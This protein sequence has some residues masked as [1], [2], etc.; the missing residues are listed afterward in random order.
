MTEIVKHPTTTEGRVLI[1]V[2]GALALVL[3][4]LASASLWVA[5]ASN[6]GIEPLGQPLTITACT[7][8]TYTTPADGEQG[9]PQSECARWFTAR[10]DMWSTDDPIPVVGQVCH[11][12]DTPVSY[13]VQV[14][15][16][17]VTGERILAIDV[18]IEYEPGCQDPYAIEWVA[19]PQLTAGAETGDS[20]GQWRV[21]GRA[22]PVDPTRWATYQWDSTATVE[23]IAG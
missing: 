4:L 21:V 13:Q 10:D 8:D 9:P 20:L 15:W 22:V 5:A 19:P 16:Q 23:L 1:A 11:S 2:L 14:A 17:S 18:P 7:P 12:G 6:T 3:G